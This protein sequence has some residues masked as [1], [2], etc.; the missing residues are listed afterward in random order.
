MIFVQCYN[1]PSE[2]TMRFSRWTIFLYIMSI[3]VANFRHKF[4]RKIN[5]VWYLYNSKQ[6]EWNCSVT[7][8]TFS[9]F[10][11]E[12]SAYQVP[13]ASRTKIFGRFGTIKVNSCQHLELLSRSWRL[14]PRSSILERG[15]NCNWDLHWVNLKDLDLWNILYVGNL[16]LLLPS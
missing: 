6:M 16:E 13:E 14:L 8:S 1:P 2:W 15:C 9:M 10:A 5:L 7:F 11:A 3:N 4:H 12:P